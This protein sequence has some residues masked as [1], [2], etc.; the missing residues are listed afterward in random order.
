MLSES[1]YEKAR[2][3]ELQSLFL[4]TAPFPETKTGTAVPEK[5]WNA[6]NLET[7]RLLKYP[8]KRDFPAAEG[9]SLLGVHLAFGTIGIRQAVR[10]A[11]GCGAENWLR[12]LAWRDFFS[13]PLGIFRPILPEGAVSVPNVETPQRLSMFQ[14]S[15]GLLY[16]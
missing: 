11:L 3:A 15:E 2:S 14:R 4:K 7:D 6:K 9:T 10:E 1:V 12:Q 5:L 8:K 16:V 13:M